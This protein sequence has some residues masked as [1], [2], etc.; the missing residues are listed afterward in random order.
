MKVDLDPNIIPSKTKKEQTE[1]NFQY[2]L[3]KQ[4]F[5]LCIMI[6]DRYYFPHIH[7]PKHNKTQHKTHTPQYNKTQHNTTQHNLYVI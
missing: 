6:G 2:I 7:T 1:S 5:Q 3:L 4:F